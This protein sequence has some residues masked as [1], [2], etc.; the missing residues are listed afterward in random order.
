M[1]DNKGF[2][3]VELLVA[4]SIL[5]ILTV[6]AIP[7]LRAFQT[8]NTQK[9]YESYAKSVTSSAK[10]YNDSYTDDL[11]GNLDYGCQKVSLTEMINK[12]MAKDITLKDITCNKIDSDSYALVWKFKD[13]YSYN[14]IINCYN[15][16][17]VLQYTEGEELAEKCLST[18]KKPELSVTVNQNEDKSSKKKSVNII[19]SDDFGFTANQEIEYLWSKTKND[20]GTGLGSY[21]NYKYNNSY[22]KRVDKTVTLTSNSITIPGTTT[23]NYYLYIRPIKV[24]NIVNENLTGVKRFGPFRFD[25][26]PPSCP[27]VKAVD[28]SGKNINKNTPAHIDHFTINYSE[29]DVQSYEIKVSYDNG[30]HYSNVITKSSSVNTY[31]PTGDG[32][33]KIMTRAIDYAGNQ[34]DWCT[35]D[36]FIN[37]NTPPNAPKVLGYKKTS[38]TDI[39][40]RG[41][42]S[43][44]A[45]DTWLKGWVFTQASGSTDA[46]GKVT[47]HYSAE[48][49]TTNTKDT[50]SSYRN[51]NAEGVSIIK[52][53]ACDSVN[54]CSGKATY[55]VKLD[56]TIPT[57]GNPTGASTTWTKNNRTI[58]QAC[59]DSYSGCEKNSFDVEFKD[60]TK[61]GTIVIKDKVGNTANCKPNVYVDKTPPTCGKTTGQSTTWTKNSRT[62]KQACSD[63]DSGCAKDSYENEFKTTTKVGTITIKDKVGNTTNCNSNVYVDTTPP[64]CGTPT[65]ASTKWTKYDRT[66]KQPCSDSGSGCE[67][68]T[69]ETKFTSSTKVGTIT[70]KDKVGNTANCKPN[71]YVDKTPPTCGKPTGA[72][73]TWTKNNRTIKQPCSDSG[74]GC[75]KSSYNTEY[76]STTKTSGV[77]IS[78]TVGNTK[79]CS[80]DV[81]VDKTPPTCGK[82]T[83]TSTTWTKENRTIKQ[84]CSDSGSGCVK[85]SYDTT[86]SSGTVKGSSVKISDSVGNTKTCSY[87]V[88]VDK[89]APRYV[90]NKKGKDICVSEHYNTEL[91]S[92]T[93]NTSAGSWEPSV[94]C[95]FGIQYPGYWY[96]S[97]DVTCDDGIGSGCDES[98]FKSIWE[99]NGLDVY[100]DGKVVNRCGNSAT[101]TFIYSKDCRYSIGIGLDVNRMYYINEYE[102]VADKVGNESKVY[103]FKANGYIHY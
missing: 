64:T 91:L 9:Q 62:I 3:L 72:S 78:D 44:H 10:L 26:T 61:V 100:S 93:V 46:N 85:S 71:V 60:T 87:D 79:T 23:G 53:W 83:G 28:P 15:S 63:S 92:G 98:K 49:T 90:F 33:I 45:T 29:D 13:E 40:S 17:D 84:P 11:F 68:T 102:I 80:Y 37:D 1:S 52:F 6:I 35:S 75:V 39:S 88:Y 66:I 81:Y 16:S 57:C 82:P 7:T 36:M 89:E 25:H 5:A 97:I 8:G 86:Y 27:T 74:S 56:R 101:K 51:V 21:T 14:P 24:L 31:T 18:T 73:T 48:G 4:I 30:A 99:H 20:T 54:N 22:I 67:K 96:Y 76:N 34:G 32:Q 94:S 55:K 41:K 95:S 70:I 47:Y 12:K 43:E 19:L 2:T 50:A 59:S 65:G 69:Y 77:T 42:L 38:V 103:Y 58:K